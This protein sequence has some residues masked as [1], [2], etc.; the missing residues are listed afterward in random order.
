MMKNLLFLVKILFY[1]LHKLIIGKVSES[2]IS[3]QQ[4]VSQNAYVT[5]VV[6]FGK[7][8]EDLIC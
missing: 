3:I 6:K 1:V 5:C 8:S 7:E 2:S 4:E